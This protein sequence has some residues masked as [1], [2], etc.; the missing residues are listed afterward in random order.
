MITIKE[1]LQ[2]CGYVTVSDET[3]KHIEEWERWYAGEVKE[4]HQYTVYNGIKR[5]TRERER[6]N[7]AKT[8]CEDWASLIL[9]E[10][11]IIHTGTRFEKSLKKVFDYNNFRV[12]GNQL[13]ELAFAFGTGAFVEYLDAAGEVVIDYIRA[14]M[15]YPLAWENGYVTECAFGSVR[16]GKGGKQIYL[17][18]H[19]LDEKKQYVIENHMVDAESGKDIELPEDMKDRVETKATEPLFQLVHPNTIN[20][21]DFDSPMGISVFGNA[22]SQ[23]KGCDL[24]YDSYLNEFS[25]GRRRIIVPV[26]M[27]KIKLGESGNMTPVF[28][29]ADTAFYAVPD[30]RGSNQKIEPMDMSIRAQEHE[31]GINKALDMLSFKCGL[32]AGRYKF[33]GGTVKTATEVISEKS[34]LYQNLKKHEIVV[35]AALKGMIRAIAFLKGTKTGEIKIDFDDSIIEDKQTERTVDKGDVAMGVMRLEEYR[36]K[37]YGE[38]EAEAAKKLPVPAELDVGEVGE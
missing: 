16:D 35:D 17:Q 32:G 23:I 18:L 11:V 31:L 29:P 8:V 38:T 2:R 3:Y 34:D 5:T 27:A 19:Q 1:Y 37:W 21:I 12:K 33:E 25:I 13:I 28:D 6:L 4:F 20:N 36:A 30:E 15:I 10:K 14:G 9:N 7:M 26:G 22:I 24:I